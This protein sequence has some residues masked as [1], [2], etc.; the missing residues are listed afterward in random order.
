MN[1]E[2]FLLIVIAL[3]IVVIIIFGVLRVLD[4]RAGRSAAGTTES[5]KNADQKPVQ[6]L[7]AH[8]PYDA[9]YA[10]VYST[11]I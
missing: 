1:A 9:F 6:R 10:P 2:R 5:F 11:L 3:S 8:N 7:R 4:I